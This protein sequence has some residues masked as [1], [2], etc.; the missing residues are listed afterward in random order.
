M[1]REEPVRNA[2]TTK[3]A[4]DNILLPR[5]SFLRGMAGILATG[6]A[7][8]VIGS[9]ILMPVRPPFVGRWYTWGGIGM[10]ARVVVVD[11]DGTERT[12]GDKLTPPVVVP[13][14]MVW[15][16]QTRVVE[17]RHTF[18]NLSFR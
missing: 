4:T 2:T 1:D 7:P 15:L 14:G 12:I 5:R 3:N 10:W 16:S 11:G 6:I 18:Q 17:I 8:A 9:G 13:E